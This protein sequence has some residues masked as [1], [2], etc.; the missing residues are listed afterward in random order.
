MARQSAS[1]E[2]KQSMHEMQQVIVFIGGC[3]V[4]WLI[5]HVYHRRSS[6]TVPDWAK[7]LVEHLPKQRPTG[8]ELLALFQQYLDTGKIEIDPLLH[9]VACPKCGE[10]A[11]RFEK[12]SFGDDS[13]TIV[14]ITC[15]ACGW[16][17]DVQV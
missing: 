1:T 2:T 16:S 12:E 5:T 13:A 11:N 3:L 14:V 6:T 10:S 7:E 9:R 4:T 17:Q 15:P 8:K